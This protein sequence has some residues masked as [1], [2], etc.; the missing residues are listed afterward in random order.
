MKQSINDNHKK[1]GRPATGTNPMFGVRM[2]ESMQ[3]RIRA[4]AAKQS[5]KP[6]FAEAIRRLVTIGLSKGRGG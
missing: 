6:S 3:G 2:D 4:W 5:D 1:R